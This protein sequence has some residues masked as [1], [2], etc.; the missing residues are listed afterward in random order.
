MNNRFSFRRMILAG[1]SLSALMAHATLAA[2]QDKTD[3]TVALPRIS[4]TDSVRSGG[5]PTAAETDGT[6][7]YTSS[8]ATLMGK[9]AVSIKE[10]PSSVS[11]ITRQVMDDWNMVTLYDALSQA[12]GVTAIPNDGTQAQ[13][14]SRGYGMNAMYNGIPSYNALSGNQQFD[15]SIYDR[16]EVLRGTAGM[17]MGTD[18]NPGGTVNMVTKRARA[19]FAATGTVSYGSWDNFRAMADVTGAVNAQKTLRVRA[20]ASGQWRD[21]FYDHSDS[22]KQVGYLTA[23]YDIGEATTVTA[24]GVVQRDRATPFYGIPVYSNLT[25]PDLPRSFSPVAPWAR[26]YTDTYEQT[27]AVE[28]RLDSGWVLKAQARWWERDF[29]FND[30]YSATAVNPATNTINYA[31]RDTSYEYFRQNVD[32]YAAGPVAL[33]GRTHNLVVGYN[34]ERYQSSNQG[35]SAPV[36]TNIP[37]F[38]LEGSGAWIKPDIPATSGGKSYTFQEGAYG[39][40]RIKVLDPLTLVAGGRFSWFT[41][42]SRSVA[43][44][45]PTDWR[46]G[47][48]ADGEFVPYLGAIYDVTPEIALYASGARTFIPQT[49]TDYTGR[50]LDP[51]K[52]TQYEVGAKGAFLD[53]KLNASLAL[54]QIEDTNRAYANPDHPNFYLQIGKVRSQGVDAEVTGQPLPGFDLTAGYSYLYT[55]YIKDRTNQGLNFSNWY[56]KHSFKLLGMYHVEDGVLAGFSL[57][58]GATWVTDY[59]GNG[60]NAKLAQ[61]G[62]A[63]FNAQAGYRIN[64]NLS[65]SLIASNIFDKKYFAALGR[66]TNTYNTY[67]TPREFTVTLTAKL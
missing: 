48:K 35:G 56:P 61:E 32:L 22:N 30:S 63:L 8:A 44:S 36:L 67:G 28:H 46:Q 64:E 13:Y 42:R 18:P 49:V 7:S 45:V 65:V 5:A 57:G 10:I 11:V 31:R 23:E 54:F 12:T 9:E 29:R 50:T 4:V 3:E 40:A 53:E 21:Y 14:N 6:G 17:L 16:V 51:R 38:N 24:T 15:L 27:L 26:M 1:L 37:L 60:S 20:V 41:T 25:I 52:G 19:D 34:R 66:S 2:A 58:G 33:F 39:Q 59:S 47:A 43:P 55:E 62:F